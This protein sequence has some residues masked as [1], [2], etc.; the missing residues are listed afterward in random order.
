MSSRYFLQP[1]IIIIDSNVVLALI[2][3]ECNWKVGGQ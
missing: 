2:N 3:D 1:Q